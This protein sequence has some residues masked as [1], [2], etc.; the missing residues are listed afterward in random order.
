MAKSVVYAEKVLSLQDDNSINKIGMEIG[1][2]S[3]DV[4][5]N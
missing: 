1:K 5:S 2:S 3:N 4:L